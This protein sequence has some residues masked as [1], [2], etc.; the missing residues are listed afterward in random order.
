MNF[1][2]KVIENQDD[3]TDL[4]HRLLHF[5]NEKKTR[6]FIGGTCTLLIKMFIFIFT[7]ESFDKMITMGDP[8]I[9]TVENGMT[10][11]DNETVSILDMS[12]V[13]IGLYE[14]DEES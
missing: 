12:K 6:S 5:D 11:K 8:T 2:V 13:M 1:L 14:F 4:S 7:I 3:I 10:T 9:L